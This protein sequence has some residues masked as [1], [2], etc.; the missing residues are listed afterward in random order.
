MN[1]MGQRL[2]MWRL[3]VLLVAVAVSTAA[4]AKRVTDQRGCTPCKPGWMRSVASR[5]HATAIIRPKQPGCSRCSLGE[6]RLVSV[7]RPFARMQFAMPVPCPTATD[8]R[9][10]DE[11]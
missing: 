4:V 6:S 8:R 3:R 5:L 10:R 9:R 11:Q 7:E 1:D 2:P